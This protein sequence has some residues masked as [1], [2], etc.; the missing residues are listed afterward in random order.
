MMTLWQ[1][2]AVD[3]DIRMEKAKERENESY[4]KYFG[5][6]MDTKQSKDFCKDFGKNLPKDYRHLKKIFVERVPEGFKVVANEP[7]TLGVNRYKRDFL[8]GTIYKP[9]E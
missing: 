1:A 2:L 3:D 5:I 4:K 6:A 7:F 8:V 9:Y